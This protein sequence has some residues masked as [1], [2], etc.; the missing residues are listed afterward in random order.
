MAAA[1]VKEETDFR[2]AEGRRAEGGFGLVPALVEAGGEA[3]ASSGRRA[4]L[5]TG[6]DERGGVGDPFDWAQGSK[7]RKRLL[8]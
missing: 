2:R 4:R 3:F 7:W 1:G 8:K 5:R 6:E